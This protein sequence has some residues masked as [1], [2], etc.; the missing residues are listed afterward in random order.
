MLLMHVITSNEPFIMFKMYLPIA[1][2]P[3]LK[4]HHP[5]LKQP[6]TTF[7]CCRYGDW[8]QWEHL[9]FI[10]SASCHGNLNL[11]N[12]MKRQYMWILKNS[13]ALRNTGEWLGQRTK[14]SR[15]RLIIPVISK[16]ALWPRNES[17]HGI[18]SILV[19]TVIRA[20]CYNS[21]ADSIILRNY[22]R[23]R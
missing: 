1:P 17:A 14:M 11:I 8:D 2:S 10:A 20:N 6:G 15:E 9:T 13:L 18:Y 3:I 16:S 22:I 12:T 4:L 19:I 21:E 5:A 23:S 7:V